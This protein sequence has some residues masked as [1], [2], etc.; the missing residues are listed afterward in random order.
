M[1][2]DFLTKKDRLKISSKSE[3]V[4][5]RFIKYLKTSN[6]FKLIM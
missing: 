6:N 1:Y 4:F 3:K 2:K 5:G